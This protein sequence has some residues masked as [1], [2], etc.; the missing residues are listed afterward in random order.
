MWLKAQP[1]SNGQAGIIGTCSA[2]GR[3]GTGGQLA[4]VTMPYSWILR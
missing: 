4:G 3:Q 2:R 1:A